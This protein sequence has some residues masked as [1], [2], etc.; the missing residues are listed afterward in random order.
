M[1]DCPKCP[2]G[3][4]EYMLTFGDLNSLLLTFFVLLLTMSTFDIVK[5]QLVLSSFKDS[6]GF[7]E[8]GTTIS[9]ERM[10]TQGKDTS[11]LSSPYPEF[12][13]VMEVKKIM[14]R[15]EKQGSM[16]IKMVERGI[17]IQITDEVLFESGKVALKPGS[18]PMLANIA[19][20]LNNVV[21]GRQVR[22][23]GHTD[24]SS[25]DGSGYGSNWEI[26]SMR[27][28][29][30]LES[31]TKMGTHPQRLSAVG[32]GPTRPVAGTV[33]EQSLE[34]QADNRRVEIVVLREDIRNF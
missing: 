8:F 12:K 31:L 6:I 3:S 11:K 18:E 28:V 1:A 5:F 24:N 9:Q 29:S 26:S 22:I 2:R 25:A 10:M 13:V 21:P 27:A 34:Q 7:M 16:Q 19:M 32:F 33:Y 15:L 4:P 23:E 20:F 30:V 17:V 14:H